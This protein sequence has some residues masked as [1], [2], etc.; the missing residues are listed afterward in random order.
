M[1]NVGGDMRFDAKDLEEVGKTINPEKDS[2]VRSNHHHPSKTAVGT[3]DELFKVDDDLSSLELRQGSTSHEERAELTVQEAV[4]VMLKAAALRRLM[5]LKNEWK[6]A[7]LEQERRKHSNSNPNSNSNPS[8]QQV[9]MNK[10]TF[11]Q[12][13]GDDELSS[14]CNKLCQ[15]VADAMKTAREL[16]DSA[17]QLQ[18]RLLDYC[19]VDGVEG[20]INIQQQQELA[21]ALNEHIAALPDDP[22]PTKSGASDDYIFGSDE[23]DQRID[24]RFGGKRPEL[25]PKKKMDMDGATKIISQPPERQGP[26][27]PRKHLEQQTRNSASVYDSIFE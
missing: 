17:S 4:A 8:R 26:S 20:R 10:N 6:Q 1:Q 13:L 12:S 9:N 22:R 25:S 16:T 23:Y 18:K 11:F 15:K 19:T 5:R 2:A 21:V 7:T 14:V 24:S 27:S 3:L